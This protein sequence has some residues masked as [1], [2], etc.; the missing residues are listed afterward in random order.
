M[1]KK[2][3]VVNVNFDFGRS[4]EAQV[5]DLDEIRDTGIDVLAG[6]EGIFRGRRLGRGWKVNRPNDPEQ[7]APG[8]PFLA[9]KSSIKSW[10]TGAPLASVSTRGAKMRLR[11]FPWAHIY[12][13]GIG[14]VKVV[15]IHMPPKRYRGILYKI[16]AFNLRR[17]LRNSKFPWIAG[18]DWN[19]F[20]EDDPADLHKKLNAK[21]IGQRID[22]WA[23]SPELADKVDKFWIIVPPERKDRHR[24]VHVIFKGQ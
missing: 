22:G 1:D 15:S 21:W 7:G 20:I 4:L 12:F 10:R 19:W 2:T 18:G 3:H 6:Q 24:Q 5:K 23:I 11:R 13:E 17:L 9:W 16:Y 14:I 8:G